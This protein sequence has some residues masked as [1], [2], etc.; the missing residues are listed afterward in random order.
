MG[1]WSG[2]RLMGIWGWDVNGERK[3]GSLR[4]AG[5]GQAKGLPIQGRLGGATVDSGQFGNR[6]RRWLGMVLE[7][8]VA[9][10]QPL[11]KGGRLRPTAK[12]IL[13]GGERPVDS[14][15]GWLG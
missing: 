6:V 9:G 15:K 8:G 13:E 14:K 11:H 12:M 7:G 10:A 2:R 5:G 3:E 1:G 4:L